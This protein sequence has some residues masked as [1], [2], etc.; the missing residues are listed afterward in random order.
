MWTCH[1]YNIAISMVVVMLKV[2]QI[3]ATEH[4]PK[5]IGELRSAELGTV[6]DVKE[7][8]PVASMR[9]EAVAESAEQAEPN[10]QGNGEGYNYDHFIIIG[11]NFGLL[12]VAILIILLHFNRSIEAA[13]EASRKE[14]QEAANEG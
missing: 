2:N 9:F 14:A 7:E 8:L 4:D 5:L 13:K 1:C 3:H 11:T 12:S 10:Q 6:K